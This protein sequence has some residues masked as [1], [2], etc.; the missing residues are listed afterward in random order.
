MHKIPGSLPVVP[1]RDD[2]GVKVTIE[3]KNVVVP[4]SY[5]CFF[6]G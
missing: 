4:E 1:I 5:G 2:D 6:G 3:L